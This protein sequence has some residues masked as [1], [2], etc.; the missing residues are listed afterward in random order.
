MEW[1]VSR[2]AYYVC[3]EDF[4]S[5]LTVMHLCTFI[6]TGYGVIQ[7]SAE[8]NMDANM[9][10]YTWA[11]GLAAILFILCICASNRANK[12]NSKRRDRFFKWFLPLII[13][14]SLSSFIILSA[15]HGFTMLF[16]LL[17]AHISFVLTGFPCSFILLISIIAIVVGLSLQLVLMTAIYNANPGYLRNQML[18]GY[19]ASSSFIGR[20]NKVLILLDSLLLLLQ[21]FGGVVCYS[22]YWKLAYLLSKYKSHPAKYIVDFPSLRKIE[23]CVIGRSSSILTY[24]PSIL[25]GGFDGSNAATQRSIASYGKPPSLAL[26]IA[27]Y[28]ELGSALDMDVDEGIKTMISFGSLSRGSTLINPNVI[29]ALD[30]LS[31]ASASIQAGGECIRKV[32]REDMP[33][34]TRECDSRYLSMEPSNRLSTAHSRKQS[35]QSTDSNAHKSINT[36]LT[37]WNLLLSKAKYLYKLSITRRELMQ[38]MIWESLHI[39]PMNNLDLFVNTRYEQWY[40]EWMHD[41]NLSFYSLSALELILFCI[42]STIATAIATLRQHLTMDLKGGSIQIARIPILV[43]RFLLQPILCIYFL[44]PLF[45]TQQDGG[46]SEREGYIVKYTLVPLM[47]KLC[48]FNRKEG[49]D[50]GRMSDSAK[51][52]SNN[53]RHYYIIMLILCFLDWVLSFYDVLSSMDGRAGGYIIHNTLTLQILIGKASVLLSSRFPTLVTIYLLY[54]LSFLILH[55]FEE[56]SNV[57]HFLI[58][59]AFCKAVVGIGTF[60]FCA[61]PVDANRRRLFT[62]YILPYMLYLESIVVASH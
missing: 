30:V 17:L 51:D 47:G 38:R 62:W 53:I 60:A 8:S 25:S 61:R 41:F 16:A 23:F 20:G 18:L 35:I 31:V 21:L 59:G 27:S 39:P 6:L 3:S 15:F 44:L 13:I 5:M 9:N 2:H 11:L 58:T 54:Y 19:M 56:H 43:F 14:A 33:K 24:N 29:K 55:F 40:V 57:V 50:S 32:F 4:V 22:R 46:T 10:E 37:F 12:L 26:D 28:R 1:F 48:R 42:Y 34:L 52:H 49:L 45:R 36:I 7:Y